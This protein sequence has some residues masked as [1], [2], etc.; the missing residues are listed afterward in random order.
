MDFHM[1]D[2]DFLPH[3]KLVTYFLYAVYIFKQYFNTELHFLLST[4]I[5]QQI[6]NNKIYCKNV[7]QRYM[8][9]TLNITIVFT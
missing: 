1:R 7:Y 4:I 2:Y 8:I 3:L 6:I 9:P 5:A